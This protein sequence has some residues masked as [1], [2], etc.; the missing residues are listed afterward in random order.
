MSRSVPR[1]DRIGVANRQEDVPGTALTPQL[2]KKRGSR[3]S[4]ERR[5]P[6]VV[7]YVSALSGPQVALSRQQ[8]GQVLAGRERARLAPPRVAGEDDLALPVVHVAEAQGD[9]GPRERSAGD[10][11][12]R[13]DG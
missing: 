5:P 6:R 4:G 8:G 9:P 13:C 2:A 12:D 11:R 1:A 10:G 3:R 7:G